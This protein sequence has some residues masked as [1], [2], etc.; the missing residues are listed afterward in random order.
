MEA[1]MSSTSRMT[2]TLGAAALVACLVGCEQEKAK[3]AAPSASTPT[4]MASAAPIVSTAP[5]ASAAE[6]KP[7]HPCP[8]ASTGKGTFE[9]P[10]KAK[11]KTRIMD[12]AWNK[13]I[14]DKG[15]TF[16]IINNAKLDVLYGK[17]VVYFYDKAG[18][19]LDVSGGDKPR[20]RLACAGDIFAGA[21]KPG[22]KVFVN[23]SCVKKEDVPKGATAIEGEV[24]TVGF[25]DDAGK[26]DTFWRN[27]DLAPEER[28]KGGIR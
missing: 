10:C 12:V 17:I 20:R 5:V 14:E 4:P 26:N 22:E 28:A 19:Q 2:R 13:K 1:I 16:R 11:G 18:K 21:V 25:T 23:F 8:E 7:V 27:D 15:P 3:P 24:Q 9:D 6:K